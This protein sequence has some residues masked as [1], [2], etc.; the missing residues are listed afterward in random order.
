MVFSTFIK[1][2]LIMVFYRIVFYIGV[3]NILDFIAFI[4]IFVG[5]LLTLRQTQLRRFLAYSSITHVGFLLISDVTASFIYMLTY[6]ISILLFFSVLLSIKT[7]GNELIY[8]NDLKYIKNTNLLYSLAIIVSIASMAG[9][10]PFAGFYGKFMVISNLIEDIYIYND[11]Y[12]YLI[13][14]LVIIL[15]LISIFY[16]IRII[17][18]IFTTDEHINNF[19]V[20]IMPIFF[21]KFIEN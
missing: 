20:E 15:T 6:L 4:S 19:G 1:F 9:L 11:L 14:L 7:F 3:I 16:Y 2:T 17:L 13:F 12:T 18:Y 10:P 8:L 5:T 21:E